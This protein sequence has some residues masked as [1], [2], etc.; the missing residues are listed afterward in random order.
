MR[1]NVVGAPGVF[2]AVQTHEVRQF[3]LRR[4]V[5]MRLD[6]RPSGIRACFSVTTCSGAVFMIDL[7][8]HLKKRQQ[9]EDAY[10]N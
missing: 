9:Q 6:P 3:G 10:E 1:S 8:T 2:C 5:E 4:K 7:H